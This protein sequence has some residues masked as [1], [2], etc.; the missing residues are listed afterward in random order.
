MM[1]T[2]A[3]L[4]GQTDFGIATYYLTYYDMRYDFADISLEVSCGRKIAIRTRVLIK[5]F[6]NV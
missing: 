4:Q 2:L 6:G 1:F 3:G 5:L